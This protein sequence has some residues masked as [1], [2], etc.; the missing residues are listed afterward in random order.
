MSILEFPP[1]ELG[2][3]LKPL[4]PEDDLLE[5]MLEKEDG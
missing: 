2:K 4:S 3:V 5:E 1:L